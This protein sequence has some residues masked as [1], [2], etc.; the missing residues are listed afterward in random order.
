MTATLHAWAD[1]LPQLTSFDLQHR[2]RGAAAA[3][4][5]AVWGPRLRAALPAALAGLWP[6]PRADAWELRVGL[7]QPG[8]PPKE[9]TLDAFPLRI[10]R[11]GG[12]ALQLPD[13]LV[14]AEH[15]E[16]QLEGGQAYVMDLRS[17]NG[18]RRNGEPLVP[19]TPVALEAGDR[20][21]LGPFT[22][23]VLKLSRAGL[24]PAGIEL[25]A[26]GPR[27]RPAAE[28]FLG[29]HPTD[30]WVR[31]RWSGETALLKVGADWMRAAW[32]RA[33]ETADSDAGLSP[34]EEGAAQFVLA[35]VARALADRLAMPVE[36][37]GWLSSAEAGRLL[38]DE[39]LW[40]EYDVWIRASSTA[41]PLT[42]L[43]P[44]GDPGPASS[45]AAWG[46]LEWPASVC[47]GQLSLRIG[48]WQRVDVGDA[49]IPDQW[50]A[51]GRA[52]TEW[53]T[54]WIRV[55]GTW[56]GGRFLASQSGAKLRLDSPW[57]S[58]AG[59]ETPMSD[60]DVRPPA[61]GTLG[62]QDLELLVSVELDRFPVTLAEL[63]RWRAGEVVSLRRAPSETVSLVV[64]TGAQ[65]R[66]LAE[67]RVVVVEGRLAV[68]VVRLL[69]RLED[70][71][72]QT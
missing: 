37:S 38:E 11:A 21:E 18:T 15:A 72:S 63:Q 33:G 45:R 32:R 62:V 17:T 44:A 61:P 4:R 57:R 49:L 51:G 52:P 16:I 1:S 66:V 70:G 67:G 28:A 20:L 14:S 35:E 41:A 69:T 27:A 55:A 24:D 31:A 42:A 71:A 2:R 59:G 46:S 39:T 30:R 36:L 48:E 12:C 9:L 65:R 40:L 68:E 54:A 53:T 19:L 23:V 10:G 60:E 64:E 7:E 29:A 34:L 47:L 56:H 25:G 3:E 5:I 58:L 26:S 22:L 43:V 50:W 6:F 13:P 8:T